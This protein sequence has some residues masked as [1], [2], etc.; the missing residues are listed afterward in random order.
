M[1]PE[2]AAH[3]PLLQLPTDPKSGTQSGTQSSKYTRKQASTT[4]ATTA[5]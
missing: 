2:P 1:A 4:P 3:W 5:L